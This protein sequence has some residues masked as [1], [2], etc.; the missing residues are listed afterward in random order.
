[1]RKAITVISIGL[2]ASVL[3]AQSGKVRPL[4]VKPGLWQVTTTSKISGMPPIPPEVLA[5]MTPE[6]RAKFG[7]MMNQ[8]ASGKPNTITRTDCVTKE[9]LNK[10]PFSGQGKQCTQTVLTST[11]SEMAVREVCVRNGGKTDMTIRLKAL[12]SENVKGDLQGTNSGGDRS[13]NMNFH[14]TGKWVRSACASG[15]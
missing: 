3:L 6:Q 7:A 11:G 13:M 2:A 1:M 14:F 10:D 9:Q 15:H 12:N 5:R 8:R 4:D